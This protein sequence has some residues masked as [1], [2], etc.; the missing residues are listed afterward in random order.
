M[1]GSLGARLSPRG[2]G[3][4]SSIARAREKAE[5]SHAWDKEKSLS[6]ERAW[7]SK[8]SFAQRL[9]ERTALSSSLPRSA[10][11]VTCSPP[12]SWPLG[13]TS[14]AHARTHSLTAGASSFVPANEV[15]TDQRAA[16]FPI[17]SSYNSR[18]HY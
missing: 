16:D 14:L 9:G 4:T 5:K 15:S 12:R 8:F 18:K 13:T 10:R 6:L 17:W 7:N 1:D 11:K 3:K 2:T